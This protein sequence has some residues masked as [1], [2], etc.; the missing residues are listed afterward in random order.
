MLGVAQIYACFLI[1]FLVVFEV[2]RRKSSFCYGSRAALTR[3]RVAAFGAHGRRLM[4]FAKPAEYPLDWVRKAWTCPDEALIMLHGLDAYAC[5][6]FLSLC[7]RLAAF[8]CLLSCCCLLPAYYYAAREVSAQYEDSTARQRAA[9]T[10]VT[11]GAVATDTDRARAD[12]AAWVA[13]L[14]AWVL[15]LVVS[16]VETIFQDAP[17]ATL[18]PMGRRRTGRLRRS[19][20]PLPALPRRAARVAPTRR[21]GLAAR[22]Q[23]HGVAAAPPARAPRRPARASA[24]DVARVCR[25]LAAPPRPPAGYSVERSRRRRGRQLDIPRER[26]AAPPRVPP[27]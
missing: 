18:R 24:G 23:L 10:R 15:A 27:G 16:R 6:A 20:R 9:F 1:L 25:A 4:V 2:F 17:L 7:V 19:P 11:L 13:V 3:A 14:G 8:C 26:V 22:G 12:G 5:A 21:P